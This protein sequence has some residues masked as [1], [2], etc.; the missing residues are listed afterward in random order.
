MDD[1]RGWSNSPN[2]TL[3]H[4]VLTWVAEYQSKSPSQ[5]ASV[6]EVAEALQASAGDVSIVVDNLTSEGLAIEGKT[7]DTKTSAAGLT[8]VGL[9]LASDM[10]TKRASTKDRRRACRDAVLDF[11]YAN[12]TKSNLEASDFL[13][14]SRSYLWG[15]R[16]TV[17]DWQEA[18][19]FLAHEKL[20]SGMLLGNGQRFIR[21]TIV[22]RGRICVENYNSD[23]VAFMS[24]A[25]GPS[26]V[27][28]TTIANSPGAQW[29]SDSP[30]ARQTATVT[31]SQDNRRQLLQIADQIAD[32]IMGLPAEVASTANAGVEELRQA[33][34]DDH[35]DEG[36]VKALLGKFALS[37]AVAAGTDA[38]QKILGLIVQAAQS[39]GS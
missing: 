6:G 19:K 38:G 10:A 14:D 22:H 21:P 9:A 7:Y 27:T 18:L 25:S 39:L 8:S 16:F 17:N 3:G 2:V 12:D 35:A 23:V 34:K 1:N 13:A 33:A 36:R 37:M 28:T 32:Q 31:I 4:R 20:I 26:K 11:L 29:M 30:G 15:E 5:I 24:P